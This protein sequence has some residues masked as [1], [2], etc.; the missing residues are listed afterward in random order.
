MP[1]LH[2]ARYR[3]IAEELATSGDA[4]I[5]ASSGLISAIQYRAAIV[6]GRPV[7]LRIAT[8]DAFALRVLNDCGE[9]PHVAT[10][11]ERR[12]AMRSAL[13]SVDHPMTE[14]RGIV[15]MMER[16][17]RD[18]RDSGL[19]LDD[20]EKRAHGRGHS[21]VLMRAWRRYESIIAALPA[22]DS[23]DVLLYAA[24]KIEAGAAIAPQVVAGFYDMTGSQLTLVRALE[25]AGKLKKILVPIGEGDAYAFASRFVSQLKS[26]LSP[27]P[28]SLHIKETKPIVQRYA[29]TEQELRGVC[30]A[31]RELIEG[32]APAMSI[33]IT[34]RSLD[35]DDIRL[36]Q[37]F[38]SENGFAI[39]A[40]ND[41]ALSAHRIGRGVSTILRLRER[42][43]A[44]ADVVDAL[45]DGF[46]PREQV[47][48]ND[49][50]KA[51]RRARISGGASAD[52]RNPNN[53]PAIEQYRAVVAELEAIPMI[54]DRI[55][56][57]FRI[58]TELDLAAIAK[59]EEIAAL[60]GRWKHKVDRETILELIEQTDLP[61]PPPATGPLL[62]AGD[63][64][65]FRGRSFEH[66]F[67]IRAQESAMPQRRV[68]DPLLPDHDRRELKIR[69]IGDGRDEERLLFQLLIDGAAAVRFSYST[70]DA[71]GKILRPS[72]MLRG[73]TT[74]ENAPGTRDPGPG[75]NHERQTQLLRLAGSRSPFDGYLDEK[76]YTLI[77]DGLETL[78]PTELENFGE[79]PQKFLLKSVFG[80]IDY[81]DPNRE[82]QMPQREKG[83]LDHTVLERFYS[84]LAMFP[85]RDIRSHLDPIVDQAFD[86]E[87]LRVP[88]FNRVMRAIERR[89]TK[90]HLRAFLD[91]DVEDLVTN[92][93][94]PMH[95]EYQFGPEP[96]VM[97][98]HA[99]PIT[100][101]GI[102]DRIDEG[103]GRLRVVDYKSG[104]S[105]RNQNLS[106]K[107]ERGIRLQ[108]AFYA[109]A[110]AEI[111]K[112]STVTGAI[113]PLMPG[114]KSETMTF[115]LAASEAAIRETLD[116]FIRS[117]LRGVFPAFPDEEACKYCPVNLSCRT[118]HSDH[119]QRLLKRFDDPRAL[120]ESLA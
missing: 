71:F 5:A 24:K 63:A 10:D 8:L 48:I 45:R 6:S 87:E 105:K 43:F 37:R 56:A 14:T 101:K 113:K 35:A 84:T 39:A 95:F 66:L 26:S 31:V 80:V 78:S 86:E 40:R 94:R 11:S 60:V 61:H 75:T 98:G 73:F 44:R 53:D 57:R 102:I 96:F 21:N 111:F 70:S 81:D 7:S 109:I 64:M 77:S 52:I 46:M 32:G 69:E 47:P 2:F 34:A 30:A 92:D 89:A 67:V 103:A 76:I 36:L 25:K 106:E 19:S 50:D 16:S 118:K 120:L 65:K 51:T 68:S 1:L 117:M 104:Q 112:V 114:G 20:F 55:A 107:I 33:G 82:L 29:N 97:S 12:L 22:V 17:Y 9:Y 119:E 59:L 49:I 54:V 93:L 13:E 115:D 74:T 41:L 23:A 27:Q 72:R 99:L 110:V 62:W 100:L 18:V 85:P 38:A 58:D 79:C 91:D 3:E 15:A 108:L 28:S 4:I 42:N 83:R 90:R 88:A 116:L